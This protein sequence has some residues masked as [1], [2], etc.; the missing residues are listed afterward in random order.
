MLLNDREIAGAI[1]DGRISVRPALRDEHLRPVGL[2]VHLR[3][4]IMIPE[5]GQLVDLAAPEELRFLRRNLRA[6]PYILEPGS[7]VLAST[8]EEVRTAPD[9]LCI[10]E[11]RSTIARLGVT[12]HNT[13][14]FLEGA[15]VGWLTPVLEIANVGSFRVVLRPGI[16]IG[17]LCFQQLSTQSS[18]RRHH[19]QY[20]RQ[21]CT[22]PP[23]LN[24]GAGLDP[25]DVP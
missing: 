20:A 17:M 11:G 3:D 16:P 10:L 21:S 22:T 23:R 18:R 7:F 13:A 4:E 2:R 9:I 24:S 5:D 12:I 25:F 6:D 1:D 14:S 15:Q 19:E 8:I